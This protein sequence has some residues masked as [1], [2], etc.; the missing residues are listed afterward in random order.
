MVPSKNLTL[1]VAATAVVAAGY[2]LSGGVGVGTEPMGAGLW[3]PVER[4]EE[5]S[6]SGVGLSGASEAESNRVVL[7]DLSSGPEAPPGTEPG[8]GTTVIY[9][10]EVELTLLLPGA[11]E[12]PDDVMAIGADATAGLEGS[13]VGASGEPAPG[14]V[15]FIYGPNTGRRMQAGA[16]GRFGASDLLQGASIVKVTVPG[17]KVAVREVVLAQLSM[18]ELHISFASVASVAG[19]ITDGAGE[20]LEAA[21]VRSDGRVVYTDVDGVF[22][23]GSVP[24]GKALISVRKPGY[25]TTRRTVGV[26]FRQRVQPGDF[27]V[28]LGEGTTLEVGLARSLGSIAPG[29]AILTPA[30]GS[31]AAAVPGSGFPWYEVNPVALPRGGRGVVEGLPLGAVAVRA[32]KDGALAVPSSKNVRLKSGA[33]N[34]VIIDLEPAPVIRGVVLDRGKPVKS[35]RVTVEAADRTTVSSKI[36]G[37]RSPRS[38]LQVVMPPIPGAYQ[39]LRT[40]GRG[41]FEFSPHPAAPTAY[42][43]TATSKDGARSGVSVVPRGGKEVAVTL[44]D[45]E[46]LT[47]EIEVELPGRFQ[48]LPVDVRIQGAPEAPQVLGAGA[49][50]IVEDLERGTWRVTASW[51]G[52][53]VVPGTVLE[54]GEKRV[55]ARGSLPSGAI[56]GQTAEERRRAEGS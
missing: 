51:R 16:R 33:A 53:P 4:A 30:A 5:D 18:A 43:V 9:P 56:Q 22:R 46:V 49:E 10:L 17:G 34:V 23:L 19:T 52:I 42:Y 2:I 11:V 27:K 40:D 8:S 31:G 14:V 20:P 39:T 45:A 21:E 12:V 32:F 1:L 15:E 44:A 48:G 37:Q 50:L 35:A 55:R 54:V 26:G 3:E 7:A 6:A 28:A 25:A 29:F 24:A 47:G 13:L 36:L 38:F 41:Q